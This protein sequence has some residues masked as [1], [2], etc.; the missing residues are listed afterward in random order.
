MSLKNIT[1]LS[2]S[3][4]PNYNG[5]INS[6]ILAGNGIFN[7]AK[8]WLG[9]KLIMETDFVVNKTLP[10]LENNIKF[11]NELPKIPLEAFELM[12][13]FYKGIYDKH[14]TEAQM[15]FYYNY[16]NLD[17]VHVK[18]DNQIDITTTVK[19][20]DIPCLKY[21][22]NGLYSHIPVQKNSAG[23]TTTDDPYYHALRTQMR[24]FVETHSHNT[25]SAFK[26]GT[27]ESNSQQEGLQLVIGHITSDIYDF[28][29]WVTIQGEQ[30]DNLERY[31]LEDIIELP[32]EFK[33]KSMEELPTVPEEY[34]KQHVQH[35]YRAPRSKQ[36]LQNLTDEELIALNQQ[37]VDPALQDFLFDEDLPNEFDSSVIETD[38]DDVQPLYVGKD[39][40]NKNKKTS[41]TNTGQEKETPIPEVA[42][43]STTNTTDMENHSEQTHNQNTIKQQNEKVSQQTTLQKEKSLKRQISGFFKNLFK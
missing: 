10:K 32:K 8:T 34:Y 7:Y 26:S 36:S 12:L 24:P 22:G 6:T 3:D 40:Y 28:F 14:G 4:E 30:Y 16:N 31:I 35:V 5:L 9:E 15:N 13:A 42:H 41:F 23:L 39:N 43:T 11:S 20:S 19:L 37:E 18:Y 17:E 25:M 27:D 38:E 21:W 2:Y 1:A 29:N 33:N